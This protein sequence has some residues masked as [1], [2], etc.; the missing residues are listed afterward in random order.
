VLKA[1]V[2]FVDWKL[3]MQQ[4]LDLPNMIARGSGFY[5]EP[6]RFAP[7]VVA[8][9]AAKGVALRAGG[10]E[11]SGLHGVMK[12]KGGYEGGADD[13]REGVAVGY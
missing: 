4:A 3:P 1:I 2:G 10:A 8:G 9:L 5:S 13:R 7:G 6:A 11:G 12:V